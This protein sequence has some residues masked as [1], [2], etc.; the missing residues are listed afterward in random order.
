MIVGLILLGGILN[1]F[2]NNQRTYTLLNGVSRLQEN[3]RFALEVMNSEIRM[4][5]FMGCFNLIDADSDSFI[6]TVNTS[7]DDYV[8]QFDVSLDGYEGGSSSWTPTPDAYVTSNII[9]TTNNI[10]AVADTDI[11]IARRSDNNGCRLTSEQPN[12]SADLKM[13]TC[14]SVS[15]GDIVLIS[16]CTKA[17]V[18]QVT[19]KTVQGG[20]GED[21]VVHNTGT[22]TPGNSQK[23]LSNDST[24]P[25]GEDAS[26]FSFRTSTFFVGTNPAV[27]N[28]DGTLVPS[29]YV[30]E[31]TGASYE[32]ARGI[33]DMQVL[34]GEDM[35]DSGVPNRY[36]DAN[37]VTDM[38]NVLTV[39]ISVTANSIDSVGTTGD[40][41]VT[42]TFT[43]TMKIR[44]RGVM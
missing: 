17:A 42:R 36:V 21:N 6:N 12:V 15:T 18:F 29:L 31:S 38:D 30:R 8:Y 26:V 43:S 5:G 32:L 4:A 13:N 25:F 22:G 33:E 7:S 2:T 41:I 24:D 11:F 37:D 35:D 40:G 20:T 1:I 10:T 39:Q 16:D 3:G 28:N 34:Y 23:E 19:S 44:N 14:P 27:V 9:N